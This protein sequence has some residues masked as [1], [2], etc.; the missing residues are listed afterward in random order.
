MW[1][2]CI[3]LWNA[4]NT[5]LHHCQRRQISA[6]VIQMLPSSSL[7]ICLFICDYGNFTETPLMPEFTNTTMFQYFLT[8]L[9]PWCTHKKG[10][11][12][13]LSD[14]V[15]VYRII[16]VCLSVAFKAVVK[17]E[18]RFVMIPVLRR[19]YWP[20]EDFLA[21]NWIQIVWKNLVHVWQG[22]VLC[23]LLRF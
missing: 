6:S 18:C 11:L 22:D 15:S 21:F 19:F 12:V 10:L 14:R 20:A 17:A 5:D 16:Q 4:V 7:P 8:N 13:V 3:E 1:A 23:H 9:H 2:N